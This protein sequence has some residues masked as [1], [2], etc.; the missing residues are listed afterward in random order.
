VVRPQFSPQFSHNLDAAEPWSLDRQ[1]LHAY[2]DELQLAIGKQHS[3][4]ART[5]FP[6]PLVLDAAA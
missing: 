1:G 6:P 5:G 4:I 3:E 2:V